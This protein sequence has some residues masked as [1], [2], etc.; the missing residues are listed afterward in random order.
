MATRIPLGISY[1]SSYLKKAGH[2]VDIFDTTFIKCSNIQNDEELRASS[3]QVRNPDFKKYNLVGEDVSV[4]DEFDQKVQSFKPEMIAMSVTDPNYNFGLEL[5]RNIK[6]KYRNIIT[7]V[8]GV[9]VTFAPEEVI[10][11]DCVDIICI[12]EGEGAV[13]EL[14]N[15]IEKKEDIKDIKNI[16]VKENGKIFKNEVRPLRDI[17]EILHP[18]WD[19][20]D[21]RHLLRPLGG[22]MYRMGIF[23]MTRGCP[24]RCTYC[25][26][27]TLSTIYK[28]KG[29]LYRV[30]KPD[31]LV[32][33]LARYKKKYNLNFIFFIDD[34]FPL[35]R[36]EIMDDFCRLYKKEVAL[37]FSVSLRPELIK[38]KDFSKIV[39]AG[40]R[41]IC[42][43]LESGSPV[44]R[45][46]VLGRIYNNDDVI[47][48]FGL[49]RKYKIRS[50]AFNM[51]GMPYETR[52]NIFESIQLNRY[53][54]PTTTT[55]T[56]LHPYR[57]TG[58]RDLCV[59]EGFFDPDREKEY[60]NVYRVESSLKLSTISNEELRGLFKTF[61]LY[62][63]L[64]KIFYGLIRV[65]EGDSTLARVTFNILKR[66]F[67]RITDKES[68][69]DFSTVS[70]G[71]IK[72][73]L[74]GSNKGF[75]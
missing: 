60:E 17:N 43:G 9:T 11:Q 57:G 15:A 59:R 28:D 3:L 1:I 72:G 6:S 50:S 53:A 4:I 64:P 68:K 38:E 67:Y 7:I 36:P 25:S 39:D 41:N 73:G 29:S 24:F 54:K 48:V 55:L 33:E 66:L 58:L 45:K 70:K 37:P 2:E 32:Q 40:C 56:F 44:I 14:C 46:V 49:A 20:F 18:D 62:F 16:W 26:N 34:L 31:V 51:I 23:G 47:R 22:K 19:I 30:K 8:G 69:W 5:L 10:A 65:A 75:F 13:S 12:G 74:N 71:R 42:V 35:H 27:F 63:K 52:K 21:D 61:Q